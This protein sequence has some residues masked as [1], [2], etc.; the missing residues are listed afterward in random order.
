MT[1]K[2]EYG[3]VAYTHNDYQIDWSDNEDCW[4]VSELNLSNKSLAKLKTAINKHDAD[5]RRLSNGG[6]PAYRMPHNSYESRAESVVVV[7]LDGDRESAWCIP[8][9]VESSRRMRGYSAKSREK[10]ELRLLAA[11]TPAVEA[12]LA[13]W[14]A[15]VDAHEETRKRKEAALGAVP[16]LT[17]EALMGL[18]EGV[19]PDPM[20]SG[21]AS[22]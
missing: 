9:D 13:D 4:T 22:P 12:A 2:V 18:R 21:D 16:R 11:K 20:E 6:V 5:Q 14:R 8:A 1:F 17:R 3:R 10:V 7:L 19:P 15:A